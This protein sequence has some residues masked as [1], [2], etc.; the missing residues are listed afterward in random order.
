MLPVGAGLRAPMSVG[1]GAGINP[2]ELVV[3]RLYRTCAIV[4]LIVSSA[5]SNP[6]PASAAVNCGP[7]VS[8]PSG[9]VQTCDA[10]IPSQDLDV[11]ARVEPDFQLQSQ[12]CW[13]ATISGVFAYYGHPVSQVRIVRDAYGGIFNMPGSPRAIM[14]SLNRPWVDDAGQPIRVTADIFTVNWMTAAQDLARSEPLI[15]GSV[16]HA[17]I[18]TATEYL[19]YPNGDGQTTSVIVR[20]PWPTN[21]RRRFLTPREASGSAS[22]HPHPRFLT[23]PVPGTGTRGADHL[24]FAVGVFC[25]ISLQ[26]A[27]RTPALFPGR[28]VKMFPSEPVGGFMM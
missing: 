2:V 10:G 17:M 18:V 8:S 7:F 19:R 27:N 16:G 11:A 13:A 21:Q 15:V 6:K 26:L 12:W 23:K 3:V 24:A 14:N 5:L 20:D 9:P 4:A 25:G 22:T 28:N 1:G